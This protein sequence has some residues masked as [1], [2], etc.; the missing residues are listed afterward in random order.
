MRENLQFALTSLM[1][2][3]LKGKNT[4]RSGVEPRFKWYLF[5]I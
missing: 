2:M 5:N 3:L 4:A 1:Y